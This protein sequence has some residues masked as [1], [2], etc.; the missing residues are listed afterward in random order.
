MKYFMSFMA[1]LH[2]CIIF[3]GSPSISGERFARI[4]SAHEEAYFFFTLFKP[5]SYVLLQLTN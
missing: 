4:Q 1:F 2:F 5:I 3:A